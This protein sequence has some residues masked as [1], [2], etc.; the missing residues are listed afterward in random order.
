M[1]FQSQTLPHKYLPSYKLEQS[2]FPNEVGERDQRSFSR[3]QQS[4]GLKI[5]LV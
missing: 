2:C 1:V 4:Y 5:H 3:V